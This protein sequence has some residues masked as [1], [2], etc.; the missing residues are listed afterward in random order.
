MRRSQDDALRL[1]HRTVINCV[2]LFPTAAIV[3]WYAEPFVLKVF[4]AGYRPAVPVLQWYGLVIV[5]ACFDF[6]P[7]LRAVNKTRPLVG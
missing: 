2:L 1:W 3:A 7:L 6:S 4:G 5:C